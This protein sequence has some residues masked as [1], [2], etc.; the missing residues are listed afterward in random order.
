MNIYVI[1]A[2]N[3]DRINVEGDRIVIHESGAVQVI[4]DPIEKEVVAV[5]PTNSIIY[6]KQS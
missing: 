5:V 6:K 2:P 1:V 4:N 3:G